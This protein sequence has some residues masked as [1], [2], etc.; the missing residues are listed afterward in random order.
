M[1]GP[2]RFASQ[3][4][5]L[6]SPSLPGTSFHFISHRHANWPG[7]PGVHTAGWWELPWALGTVRSMKERCPGQLS[8]GKGPSLASSFCR[9]E[10]GAAGRLCCGLGWRGSGSWCATTWGTETSPAPSRDLLP[11]QLT[12][13]SRSPW[14]I[15]GNKGRR[16]GRQRG[17]SSSVPWPLFPLPPS[18]TALDHC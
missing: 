12:Q 16:N 11:P 6:L 5:A 15:S 14:H 10:T 18:K 2:R 9:S 17:L 13:N 4:P 7:K 3:P 8:H 1:P